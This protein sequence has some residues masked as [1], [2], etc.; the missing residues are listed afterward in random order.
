MDI[1]SYMADVGREARAASRLMARA[2]T[3]AKNNALQEAGAAIAAAR[4]ELVA[5]NGDDMTRAAAQGLEQVAALPDPIGEIT[6]IKRRPSGIQVGK[7]RVP[8]G[9]IGII[10]EARPNVTADA[11]ACA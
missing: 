10:Y 9:V 1:G 3:Q 4:A 6:D 5:A 11:A 2:T 8:L 7:M